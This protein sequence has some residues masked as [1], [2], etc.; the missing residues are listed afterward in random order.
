MG[1][2]H[3]MFHRPA[4]RLSSTPS[5]QRTT[6][7]WTVGCWKHDLTA[8]CSPWLLLPIFFFERQQRR[9]QDD[10]THCKRRRTRKTLL[11]AEEAPLFK[12]ADEGCYEYDAVQGPFCKYDRA[13]GF[14]VMF[15]LMALMPMKRVRWRMLG[16]ELLRGFCSED[17]SCISRYL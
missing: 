10:V 6:S 15:I 9:I 5:A 11:C 13:G 2:Y 14:V 8:P 17:L 3:C 1:Q 4:A 16:C 7:P 12:K